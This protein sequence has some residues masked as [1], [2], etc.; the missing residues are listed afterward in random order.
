MSLITPGGVPTEMKSLR[1]MPI[2]QRIRSVTLRT[3]ALALVLA[4]LVHLGFD[5]YFIYGARVRDLTALAQ[6]IGANSSAAVMFQD[7]KSAHEIL[8][9]LINKTQVTTATLYL[10]D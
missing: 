8:S 10:V 1:D 2:T 5:C 9:G 4:G 3:C 6:V 7:Q